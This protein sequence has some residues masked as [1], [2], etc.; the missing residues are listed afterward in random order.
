MTNEEKLN[1]LLTELKLAAQ[2]KNCYDFDGGDAYEYPDLNC[3]VFEDGEV[4]GWTSFAR[5]LLKSMDESYE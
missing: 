5:G 2:H 4:Y 3:D 1:F